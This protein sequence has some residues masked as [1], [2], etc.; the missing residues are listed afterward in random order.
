SNFVPLQMADH[1]PVR[2]LARESRRFFPELLRAT[3][4]EM[5]TPRLQDHLCQ[6][7]VNIL[8]DSD[9]ADVATT[10]V[11]LLRSGFD[12]LSD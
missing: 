8:G 1:V 11:G 10:S 4:S 9:Q 5:A 12:L 6:I 2:F 7:G 3:F